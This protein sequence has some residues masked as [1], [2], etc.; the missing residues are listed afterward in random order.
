MRLGRRQFLQGAIAAGGS[1]WAM[2]YAH[3]RST[4]G[5]L[6]IRRNAQDLPSDDEVFK[7]YALAVKKMHALPAT[8]RRS[9]RKQAEVHADYC[10][11]GSSQ[12][13]PWHR[14]YITQF[15][16]ICGDLIGNPNF[17]LP[18]WDWTRSSG[19]IPDAFFDMEDLNVT[20]WNDNGVYTGIGWGPVNTVGVR[21]LGKGVG[22]QSDP[23]GGV[24]THD[25][26]DSILHESLFSD[27]T[28]RLEG[29]P[30][31]TGHVIVGFSNNP[32]DPVGHMGDGLSPLDPLFWLHHCNVDRQW[33]LW[34]T[35]GN[36]TP[37]FSGNYN[38][39]FVDTSGNPI[40]VTPEGA[41]DFRAMGFT[42]DDFGDPVPFL[43][44]ANVI[45][46]A[47]PFLESFTIQPVNNEVSSL[48]TSNQPGSARIGIPK[49]F[50]VPV[51]NLH[52]EVS[53]SRMQKGIDFP[54]WTQ[55]RGNW[56]QA[57]LSEFARPRETSRRIQ[58]VL[59][60]VR[61][62]ARRPPVVNVFLNCPYLAP[63]TPYTDSHYAGTFAF[64]GTGHG[65]HDDEHHAGR[66]VIIDLAKPIRQ[67]GLSRNNNLKVQLMPLGGEGEVTFD[68][69]EIRGT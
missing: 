47:K 43:T 50:D 40:N 61:S 3:A 4:T 9:W 42:Y 15:E 24:F 58:A 1:L 66:D 12:F 44:A 32:A 17:A 13:L 33:A 65:S 27:F 34:Q 8:D 11:H 14:H 6:R 22:L 64:F 59:K 21:A 36:S 35:A 57:S 52:A 31:N 28:G 20:H 38:G 7:Q 5:S 10:K 39:N 51:T 29:E 55:T 49:S 30:H 69:I 60:N 45:N 25:Y 67:L 26:I 23:R 53:R 18:Y 2:I 46:P 48:G 16:K 56:D 68:K 19:K 41:K 37:T 54:K 63:A 62:T